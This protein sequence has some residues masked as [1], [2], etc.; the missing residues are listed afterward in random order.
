MGT[1]RF[2]YSILA[3]YLI[4]SCL[5]V[6]LLGQS[7]SLEPMDEK[8]VFLSSFLSTY[9][10]Y[11]SVTGHEREAGEFFS[12]VCERQGLVV[13]I[14]TDKDDS[15]N[16]VAS[17]Y[18]LDCGKPNIILLNHI[19]VVDAGKEEQW[20]FPPFSGVIK[21]DEIWGRGAIDN[22]AMGAMELA[23]LIDF[24]E[25]A[26]NQDL[27]FNV[28]I[29]SV[30]GEETGGAKGAD[31]V[32]NQ[33]FQELNPIVVLGE[34]GSGISGV[35]SS[36]P[37]RFLYGIAI[38]HK[39]ALWL[40]LTL[41]QPSA[42]HGSVPTNE[43]ATMAMV[44]A[45]DRLNQRKRAINFSSAAKIMFTELSQY[46][47]GFKRV[48]LRNIGFFK[49]FIESSLRKEP[50]IHA[51]VTNT[52]TLTGIRNPAGAD[53][54]VPQEVVAVLDCRLLPETDTDDFLKELKEI[55]DDDN[56]TI[57]V[58]K[59]TV[60]ASDTQ[61]DVFYSM[62]ETSLERI[63]PGSKV[64][65]I[66][67]PASNDNN[68]FRAKGIA[69][70]G[71]LPIPM[72]EEMIEGVHNVNERIKISVLVS[73]SE[74]YREFLFQIFDTALL[75]GALTQT[76]RG[77]VVDKVL[78]LPLSDCTVILSNDTAA[79][80][81]S[82]SS[83]IGEFKMDQIPIGRYRLKVMAEGYLSVDI[84]GIIVNTGRE[85]V[86]TC[87]LDEEKAGDGT[88][89]NIAK[90]SAMN[91]MATVSTKTFDLEE[92]GRYPGSR[93]DPARMV[94]NY[95]GV[96]G[97]DDS[98]ND[99]IVRGNSPNGLR[100][101]LE[102]IDL[103]NPNHF[104][105]F[106]TS[107]GGVNILNSQL[108]DRSDF[109]TGA[110]PA[111]FGNAVAGVFDLQLRAGNNQQHE[112]SVE[113]GSIQTGLN[114]EG[115]LHRKQG[116]SYVVSIRN[117][118]LGLIDQLIHNGALDY[119]QRFGV[120]ATPHF[121]DATFK[122]NVPM[123]RKGNL[124]FFGTGGLSEITILES[125]R[126][127]GS[128]SYEDHGQDVTF[129]SKMGVVGSNYSTNLSASTS[130]KITIYS[131]YHGMKSDRVRIFRDTITQA[132]IGSR[133]EYWN[134]SELRDLGIS[135][136]L[137]NKF[138]ARHTVKS[139]LTIESNHYNMSDTLLGAKVAGSVGSTYTI[140]AFSQWRYRFSHNLALNIGGNGIWFGL[141][142]SWAIDPRIGMVW[143]ISRR[144]VLNVAAGIHSQLQPM[145]LYFQEMKDVN[146]V[147][148]LHNKRVGLTRSQHYVIGFDRILTE[149]LHWRLEAY[150]E[151][152]THIPV[153]VKQSSWSMVN[154]G[155]DFKL[156]F[157]GPLQNTG[158][159]YNYGLEFTLER[160]FNKQYYY[161]LTASVFE[162]KYT[163][164]DQVIRNT[165]ANGNYILNVVIGREFS[166]GP[167]SAINI[168]F[169]SNLSGG[170]RHTPIDLEASMQR[171]RTVYVDSLAY[172]SQFKDYFRADLKLTYRFNQPRITHELGLDLIN[173]IPVK[174]G[175][176]PE[177]PE[178]CH[179]SP[180]STQN[181]LTS[182]YDPIER[183]VQ[184][185]YQLGFLPILY[186]RLHF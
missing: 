14:L 164:S 62:L 58:I 152:L 3:V 56:I 77:K 119:S 156:S 15:Y 174:F 47:E 130:S 101:R 165:D 51:L 94:A 180:L 140:R 30:S 49:P 37:Q 59:E 55:L 135:L 146:G 175:G 74:V 97:A 24:V 106:G 92:T 98:R 134:D 4:G 103:P 22:K 61:P 38:N 137:N 96:R 114:V 45:L 5:S 89:M 75:P 141:N 161:L 158:S 10:S 72:T 78:G 181:V 143:H 139:G 9:L 54:Q 11:E 20:T 107:G 42:G 64:A 81:A 176:E 12:N 40:H 182:L 184:T 87:A 76:V 73:G 84:P 170:R 118:T 153:Q 32:V 125:N 167:H 166:V 60:R 121:R 124:S 33:F 50:I 70:Y 85:V 91:E 6:T 57:D 8:E 147:N 112:A 63:Y 136:Q 93:D 148:G 138:F 31:L 27:P 108:L 18:P 172:S 39:R 19:D 67:F 13:R 83:L 88:K 16:F 126:R 41:I 105:I 186:Y 82:R 65:P 35:I 123:K 142:Q 1:S 99:I 68:F 144:S 28:S 185:E 128:F 7:N 129:G 183:K 159:A 100:W 29:L 34:G 46:E 127:P 26:A 178:G 80:H 162:S 169:R 102:D 52:V 168:G 115:P 131:T 71:I 48:A 111:E 149:N 25:L 179:F 163:G 86:L 104:A 95:P 2:C 132:I 90:L 150:L 160:T 151:N 109:Y 44:S 23:A 79:I 122:V 110:F 171:E 177:L 53:N 113:I 133:Q 43:N 173:I 117:S 157:P 69:A 66:L 145:Y 36:D 17:L 21:D 116:S 155:L 120:D 154:E